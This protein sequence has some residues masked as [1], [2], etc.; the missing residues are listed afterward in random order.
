MITYIFSSILVVSCK[1]YPQ[2]DNA[3]LCVKNIGNKVIH[4]AWNTSGLSDSIMPG[5]S[6][7]TNV[8]KMNADPN[9]SETPTTYFYSDHGNYAITVNECNE[10]K[11]IQ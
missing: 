9:N 1:K 11:D 3:Q 6:A 5:G 8:G 2:C 7:C 4:Y 10:V